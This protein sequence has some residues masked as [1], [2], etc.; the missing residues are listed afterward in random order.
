MKKTFL[1]PIVLFLT[2]AFCA[3]GTTV[4]EAEITLT[5]APTMTPTPTPEPTPEIIVVSNMD[6]SI[7]MP[8]GLRTGK[9]SGDT[10]EGVPNGIGRFDSQN[11]AGE[12]WWYVGEWVDGVF[13]GEGYCEWESGSKNTGIYKNYELNGEGEIKYVNGA[14][15]KGT[16]VDGTI[17]GRGQY[18]ANMGKVLYEGTFEDGKLTRTQEELDALKTELKTQAENISYKEYAKHPY[19]YE[20]KLLYVKGRVAWI[21]EYNNG[22]I[23]GALYVN[24]SYSYPIYFSYWIS[25]TEARIL[26]KENVE[27]WGIFDGI[28]SY[29][30]IEGELITLPMLRPIVMK[31]R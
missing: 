14:V 10:I 24:G 5:P 2:I 4:T 22:L 18:L 19:E 17:S 9:Y 16:F 8:V 3:C 28:Y 21:N 31:S 20:G 26:E 29:E 7:S 13:D 27:L 1:I 15:L 25:K 11:S 12:K 30:S 23:E 6:Y